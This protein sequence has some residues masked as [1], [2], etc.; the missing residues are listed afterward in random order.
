M[1]RQRACVGGGRILWWYN[2]KI[3]DDPHFSPICLLLRNILQSFQSIERAGWERPNNLSLIKGS[4]STSFCVTYIFGG[5]SKGN[6]SFHQ[7]T[8]PF[9]HNPRKKLLVEHIFSSMDIL[10]LQFF[11]GICS[12]LNEKLWDITW[13]ATS[14]KMLFWLKIT[15]FKHWNS[16]TWCAS[17]IF[18]SI[19]L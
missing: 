2:I 8:H 15:S 4:I 17:G 9:Q 13:G 14:Q 10:P 6:C 11:K 3:R 19:Q 7:K 5:S 12:L 16:Y 1:G 18:Q